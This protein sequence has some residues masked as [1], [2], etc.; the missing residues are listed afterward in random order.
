MFSGFVFCIYVYF[1][2]LPYFKITVKRFL[3][4]ANLL[5]LN[6]SIESGRGFS[7]VAEEIRNLSD[8]SKDLIDKIGT[9]IKKYLDK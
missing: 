6:A 8:T 7:V 2:P 3:I 5:G 4:Q 9:I 1:L